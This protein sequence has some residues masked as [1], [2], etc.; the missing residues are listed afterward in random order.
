MLDAL[1]ESYNERAAILEF[2]AG[3][4]RQRAKRN[5]WFLVFCQGCVSWQKS[6][7]SEGRGVDCGMFRAKKN[8]L[9]RPCRD[10]AGSTINLG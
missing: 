1:T 5:A 8:P 6:A 7:C 4:D 3:M 9:Q 2:D 10:S